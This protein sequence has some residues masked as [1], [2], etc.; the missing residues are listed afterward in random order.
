MPLD[1]SYAVRRNKSIYLLVSIKTHFNLPVAP[2]QYVTPMYSA[3]CCLRVSTKAMAG[4]A[5]SP[6]AAEVA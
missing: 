5:G 4:N 3:I 1:K 2:P 6:S